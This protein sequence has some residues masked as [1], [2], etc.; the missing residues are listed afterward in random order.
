M[1]DHQQSTATDAPLQTR[2]ITPTTTRRFDSTTRII[3]SRAGDLGVV[4]VGFFVVVVAVA[5]GS[6]A[7][8]LIWPSGSGVYFSWD[9]G[10]ESVAAL[11]GGLYFSS[12][13]V[14]AYALTRPRSE[15]VPLTKGVLAL[16]LPT[17]LFTA[18]HHD[19]FDWSRVQAGAWVVLFVSA[20]LSIGLELRRPSGVDGSPRAPRIACV[21]VAAVAFAGAVLACAMW[22]DSTREWLSSRSPVPLVGLTGRYLGAWCAFV[23]VTTGAAAIRGRMS[24]IRLAG[25]LIGSVA[26]GSLTAAAR[27]WGS[28][29]PNAITFVICLVGLGVVAVSVLVVSGRAEGAAL[30]RAS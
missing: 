28:L 7:A 4:L 25:V 3:A 10:A 13:M 29:G 23:S 18:R 12:V 21:I 11:I 1:I 24:D 9:L 19:V 2:D 15:T 27:T 6:A 8:L 22:L 5:G 26:I 30:R 17:L 16:A 14:F 20:P